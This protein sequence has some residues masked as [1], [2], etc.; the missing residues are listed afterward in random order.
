MFPEREY[1]CIFS[2]GKLYK[3]ISLHCVNKHLQSVAPLSSHSSL[4]TL[5]SPSKS[6]QEQQLNNGASSILSLQVL[7]INDKELFSLNNR[8]IL[9]SSG[10][11]GD[12]VQVDILHCFLRHT[13]R[14][15]D[16]LEQPAY[17]PG[18]TS[19]AVMDQRFLQ[20][21]GSRCEAKSDFP[22]M[23]SEWKTH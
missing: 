9:G 3:H 12:D 17:F 4:S 19:S 2:V 20:L 1:V 18:S 23:L 16:A 15:L 6:K 7:N 8:C 10:G 22:R 13:L 11:C 21:I 14:Y 5:A